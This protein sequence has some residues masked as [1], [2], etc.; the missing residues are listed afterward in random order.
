MQGKQT[1]FLGMSNQLTLTPSMQQALSILQMSAADLQ[2]TVHDMLESNIMLEHVEEGADDVD[3]ECPEDV[4]PSVT[5]SRQAADA[6]ADD[7][8][9]QVA[10]QPQGIQAWVLQQLFIQSLPED[11]YRVACFFA[12]QLDDAGYLPVKPDQPKDCTTKM[13]TTAIAAI[14]A[15]EPTGVGARDLR[16]CLQL[17]LQEQAGTI[18]HLEY[19]LAYTLIDEHLERITHAQLAKLP[20]H[21]VDDKALFS[22]AYARIRRLSPRPGDQV[23]DVSQHA[24]TPD[25]RIYRV[26]GELQLSLQQSQLPT[27][28]INE[29]YSAH[30]NQL[31]TEEQVLLRTHQNQARDL[32]RSLHSRQETLLRVAEALV[33]YQAAF[34]CEGEQAIRPMTLNTLANNLQIHE[35]TVSRAIANKYVQTPAGV[36]PLKYF[37]S[38]ELAARNGQ[39]EGCSAVAIKA[40]LQQLVAAEDGQAPL[41]DQNIA[42]LLNEEGISISRR[43]IT[44]YR[45]ALNIPPSQARRQDALLS[46][47]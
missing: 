37:F 47:A 12:D 29:A 23:L 9:L 35:S 5:A 27:V 34:F 46:V 3:L 28:R 30:I 18:D 38:A 25:I 33:S 31:P 6:F 1:Q 26:D 32:I 4:V 7:R 36:Y 17:Q 24:V 11:I 43:T 8:I 39:R 21:L 41:N 44:K 2:D 16:E 22:N 10:E 40:K 13:A 45:Q 15:C 14:Q 42:N 19:T 20:A